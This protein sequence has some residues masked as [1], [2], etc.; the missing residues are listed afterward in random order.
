MLLLAFLSTIRFRRNRR[1]RVAD[2]ESTRSARFAALRPLAWWALPTAG[3]LLVAQALSGAGLPSLFDPAAVVG[4][5]ATAW[6]LLTRRVLIVFLRPGGWAIEKVGMRPEVAAQIL[7]SARLATASVLCL[8]VPYFVLV[9]EPFELEAL[10]RVLDVLWSFL[11]GTAILLLLTRNGALMQKWARPGGIVRPVLRVFGPIVIL[12]L[13]VAII[14]GCLGYDAIG[15][16]LLIGLG[17]T[18]VALLGLGMLYQVANRLIGRIASRVRSRVIR[19]E[20]LEAA[21]KSSTAVQRLLTNLASLLV[22]AAAGLLLHEFWGLGDVI[23]GILHDVRFEQF[24]YSPGE[25]LTLWDVFVALAWVVVGHLIA[26]NLGRIYEFVF[27]PLFGSGNKGTRFAFLTLARYAILVASYAAALL[28]LRIELSTLGWMATAVSVGLGFGLQEIVAN[29]ISGLILLFERPIRVGDIITVGETGGTV[30]KIMIRATVVTNW[31]RQTII[32]PNKNFITQNLTNWTR[33]DQVMRR[34]LNLR[35]AYGSDLE[36]VVRVLDGLLLEHSFV[37]SDP[38]HR[39]WIRGMGEYGIELEVWFFATI[40][41]GLRT[42]TEL[43]TQV[44]EAFQREGI[45]IPVPKR[46]V[47]VTAEDSEDVPQGLLV[48]PRRRSEPRSA[49]EG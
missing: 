44:Y 10:P 5:R 16:H 37:L 9:G 31:E 21:A 2:P 38:Q 1:Q 4:L 7:R 22:I 8:V 15:D 32:I 18:T 48:D 43:Y 13:V 49:A 12:T 33:N 23:Y 14:L 27:E 40:D 6:I 34:T 25:F 11:C 45:E 3:L 35:I 28:L 20:G 39:I 47:R 36:Q 26:H 46:D 30:E 24:E 19:E 17:K 41:N 29:F 42:R